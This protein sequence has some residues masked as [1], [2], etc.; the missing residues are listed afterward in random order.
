[1][2]KVTPPK[3]KTLAEG[4]VLIAKQMQADAGQL[5]PEHLADLESIVFVREGECIFKMNNEDQVLKQGD[6]SI[7]PAD[8]RHQI[9]ATTDFKGVHF[10]P[11]DIKFKFFN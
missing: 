5:L 1:M 4:S 8:V 10:M 3:V 2:K 9:E 11:K 7:V 6:T